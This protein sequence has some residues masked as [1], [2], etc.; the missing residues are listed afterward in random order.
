MKRYYLSADIEGIW[1]NSDSAYTVRSGAEYE[2]YRQNMIMEVNLAVSALFANG[3][4]EVVINDGHGGMDN[5]C[6]AQL[7][8]RAMMISAHG[9][10][11]EYGMMEGISSDFEGVC[12][13]G[14]HCRSNTPG[15]M[16]HTIWGS[17]VR[18]I[19]LNGKEVGEAAL[20]AHL[21]WAFGVPVILVSGDSLLKE[22]LKEEISGNLCYIETKKAVNSLTALNCSKLDLI[23]QYKTE[24]ARSVTE[25][26]Q[27]YP[28]DHYVIDITFHKERNAAFV[29]RVPLST[30][31]D[32][33]TVRIEGDDYAELYRRMRFMIKIA[34]AFE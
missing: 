29:A 26:H 30:R 24:T 8:E 31:P 1:G 25:N 33:C 11:K 23:H 19:K 3:A 4:D 13:I 18:C 27:I 28:E 21:A 9:A 14:Y 7:D 15:V 34:N 32:L 10:Y 17:Q 5:L 20:N 2:Q 16:A 12:L 6:A 22:Q